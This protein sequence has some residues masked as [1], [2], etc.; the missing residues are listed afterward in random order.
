MFITIQ[1]KLLIVYFQFFMFIH[2]IMIRRILVKQTYR[3]KE[4][5]IPFENRKDIQFVS[6]S[7]MIFIRNGIV[8]LYH[9]V[10]A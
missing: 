1:N 8:S 2:L 3:H 9:L 10:V 6:N 7:M 5:S 4:N